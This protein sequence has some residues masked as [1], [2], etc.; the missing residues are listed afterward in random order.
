MVDFSWIIEYI[1]TRMP[2]QLPYFA[3]EG[4]QPI[5]PK[6]SDLY[7]RWYLDKIMAVTIKGDGDGAIRYR[8]LTFLHQY[9]PSEYSKDMDSVWAVVITTN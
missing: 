9:T 6:V 1:K 3:S 7:R 8:V 4:W 2:L 5:G